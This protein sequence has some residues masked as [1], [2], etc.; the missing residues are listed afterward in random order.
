M[1]P[2]YFR[3]RRQTVVDG[4]FFK[5]P[6]RNDPRLSVFIC[7][8]SIPPRPCFFR[9]ACI[10][11]IR[12]NRRTTFE[13]GPPM[14]DTTN[15]P[16]DEIRY[17]PITT[18]DAVQA[19][20]NGAWLFRAE[21][22]D[23][24][25]LLEGITD[26]QDAAGAPVTLRCIGC[27]IRRC[28]CHNLEIVVPINL[29]PPA[30]QRDDPAYCTVFTQY[31][32]FQ[33][34]TFKQEVDF[35]AAKFCKSVTLKH[36][37]FAHLSN[38]SE[39]HFHDELLCFGAKFLNNANFCSDRFARYVDFTAAV[40]GGTTEFCGSIFD[41]TVSFDGANIRSNLVLCAV[42]IHQAMYFTE[43]T[44]FAAESR[45]DLANAG[46][47]ASGEI[48]LPIAYLDHISLVTSKKRTSHT[49]SEFESAANQ[50]NMLRD[51]Y[52]KMAGCE[53]EGGITGS[54]G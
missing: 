24:R 49:R 37:T 51:N 1:T 53:P 8:Y 35:N 38:F 32:N 31:T 28:D 45:V 21:I 30:K 16:T 25:A 54:C 6:H 47:S 5:A 29:S 11:P 18:E 48:I 12:Y 19:V 43:R 13:R 40:F 7:G 14:P 41:A 2:S 33:G 22:P 42:G 17:I 36:A 23:F 26:A 10:A 39:V 27:R 44:S 46:L 52:R 4:G 9:R 20:K 15:N 50:F 3:G 34:A